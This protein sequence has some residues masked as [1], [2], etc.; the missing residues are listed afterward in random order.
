MH[1]I[2]LESLLRIWIT[3]HH[4]VRRGPA[5]C[6][7]AQVPLAFSPM[8]NRRTFVAGVSA[9]ENLSEILSRPADFGHYS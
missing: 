4:A 3:I 8:P 9:R 7:R 5:T 6:G 1:T 2:D